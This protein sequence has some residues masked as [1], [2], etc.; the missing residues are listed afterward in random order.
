MKYILIALLSI[1]LYASIKTDMLELYKNK[2]YK[3]VCREGFDNFQTYKKDEQYVSIYAFGCL[4]ADYIDRLTVPIA[5]LKYSKEA[6]AN[7]TYFSVILMQKKML[8]HAL[9]DGYNI[10]NLKLPS[11]DYI[12]SKV[13]DMY[14]KLKKHNKKFYIFKD[15]DN[16]KLM[17]KLYILKDGQRVPKMVIEEYIDSKLIK[18][19]TYW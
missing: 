4:N 11:T 7:A 6:R 2:K 17:Y 9:A 12:L 8:Y 14:V 18:Q 1:N 5:A 10:N 16:K 3:E 19:H 15:K 13:F